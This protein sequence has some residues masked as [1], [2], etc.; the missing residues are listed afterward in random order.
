MRHDADPCPDD[1]AGPGSANRVHR[2]RLGDRRPAVGRVDGN[3]VIAGGEGPL[4]GGG[5]GG[6][7]RERRMVCREAEAEIAEPFPFSTLI[8]IDLDDRAADPES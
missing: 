6:S 3:A 7:R 4:V 8:L 5:Q 2:E 1:N